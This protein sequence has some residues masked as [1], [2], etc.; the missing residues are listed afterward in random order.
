MSSRKG[1]SLYDEVLW[2]RDALADANA[3]IV[4]AAFIN[5]SFST[6]IASCF[7]SLLLTLREVTAIL[8]AAANDSADRHEIRHRLER[9]VNEP[10]GNESPPYD[11]H[12]DGSVTK[13]KLDEFATEFGDVSRIQEL[14][15]LFEA[16]ETESRLVFSKGIG[17]PRF[18]V[19]LMG[20]E[21]VFSPDKKPK[22]HEVEMLFQAVFDKDADG[23]PVDFVFVGSE[24]GLGEPFSLEPDSSQKRDFHLV[25]CDRKNM[26]PRAYEQ[27][28]S[29][30]RNGG[31]KPVVRPVPSKNHGEEDEGDGAT[32]Q[33][34]NHVHF[35][36][37]VSP[38]S[39]LVDNF[40]L[41]AMGL[42]LT[43]P[44]KAERHDPR[45][46]ALLKDI[47][48]AFREAVRKGRRESDIEI[49]ALWSRKELPRAREID[50]ARKAV[51]R[52]AKAMCGADLIAHAHLTQTK[53]PED[54]DGDDAVENLLSHRLKFWNPEDREEWRRVRRQIGSNRFSAT[55]LMAIADF[56]VVQALD[57][58]EGGAE[59]QTF[60]RSTVDQVRNVGRDRREE[61]ILQIVI[62]RYRRN[63]VVGDPDLDMELHQLVL[64]HLAVIGSPTSTAVLVRLPEFREYYK[65]IAVELDYSRRRH[66]T[67]AL[68]TMA[69]RGLV[70]RL[71]AHPRLVRLAKER[72]GQADTQSWPADQDFRYALHRNV[73]SFAINKL[74]VGSHDPVRNNSFAPRLYTS[75]PS[76]GTGLSYESYQFLRSLLIGL[77]QYPDVQRNDEQLL[78]WLFTT[79]TRSVKVQAL[80]AA[81][82]TARSTLSVA[83]LSRFPAL[84]EK[85]VTGASPL[86]LLENY[87]L[88]MRWIIRMSWE[89]VEPEDHKKVAENPAHTLPYI[90]AL[91]RDEIVWT[92]NELGVIA[93]TQGNMNEALG[94]L[95]Q[96]AEFNEGVEGRSRFG[97]IDEYIA[98]NHAIVQ[99]ERGR[100]DSAEHRLYGIRDA[101]GEDTLLHQISEGYLCVISHIRGR[102]SNLR[103]RFG[104]VVKA[105]QKLGDA[106]ACAL[107]MAHAAR[108]YSFNRDPDAEQDMEVAR[109]M[110][111][112]SGH[113]DVRHH[114]ENSR[115]TIEFR[116]RQR[117][118]ENDVDETP[119]ALQQLRDIETYGR[120]MGIWSLQVDSLKLRAEILLMEGETSSAGALLVR[121]MAI[122]RR[123]RM[124][125][126]LNSALTLYAELLM[127]REDL[128][129]ARR[130]ATMSLEMAKR[131][132]YSLQ[133]SS[134]QRIL[135]KID[136]NVF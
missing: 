115:L 65:R 46:D 76:I 117:L 43:N 21:L 97:P 105:L 22:N 123:Y 25:R 17:R 69:Y 131:V 42:Y 38:V 84:T 62:E 13:K 93:L 127:R 91:Y 7:D 114:I 19:C 79:N 94:F 63:Q 54:M 29:R 110:A 132:G 39:L 49:D 8:H 57:P 118:K 48:K 128:E 30:I 126:R 27:I 45:S 59:A 24:Y 33:P 50:T 112:T 95:R 70:F 88:R 92:Y 28:E 31:L 111:E 37:P 67:R 73:T 64:R 113:E 89:L 32:R 133:T 83:T 82:S 124:I 99:M 9:S 55:L 81:L 103:P 125:L 101:H 136:P 11:P 52:K 60:I 119:R 2:G 98:L 116:R 129:G 61:L 53:M 66:L 78:P 104:A 77:S 85:Q 80:R 41:L 87:K 68:T 102:F 44:P 71:D 6:E 134:A 23:V 86:G 107:F 120:R 72:N 58:F 100:L 10:E 56:I 96:A 121:A 18:L 4:G 40:P 36:R 75:M 26:P 47:K 20:L 5:L 135:A 51:W 35:A 90:N 14:S 34:I 74:G 3:F 16:F 109:A 108:F 1:L 15:R 106:R 122:A 12:E 130:H